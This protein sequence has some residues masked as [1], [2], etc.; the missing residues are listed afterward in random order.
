[1]LALESSIVD[2]LAA[3]PGLLGVYGAAE[4]SDLAKSGKPSPCAYVLY[5]GYSVLQ[6]SDDGETA[7]VEDRWLVVLSLKHAGRAPGAEPVREAAAPMIQAVLGAMMGWQ[8]DARSY[9]AF[10]LDSAPR[11]EPAPARLLFPLA[12]KIEHIVSGG[13]G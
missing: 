8:P 7:R 9:K 2:R 3:V 6:S 4:F 11:P 5:G 13:A 10:K 1:M 12:F